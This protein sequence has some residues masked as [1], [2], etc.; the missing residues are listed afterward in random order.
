[1]FLILFSKIMLLHLLYLFSLKLQSHFFFTS[2]GIHYLMFFTSIS[3]WTKR[4]GM[5]DWYSVKEAFSRTQKSV[6]VS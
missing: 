6:A 3:V 5:F 4:H 2:L 1:M